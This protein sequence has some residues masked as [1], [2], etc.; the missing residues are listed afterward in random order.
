MF[1]VVGVVEGVG[2][3]AQRVITPARRCS[4]LERGRGLTRCLGSGDGVFG[5]DEGRGD[6]ATVMG[7]FGDVE[8]VGG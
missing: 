5:G 3:K 1:V 8:G 7:L 2:R 4:A 6:E